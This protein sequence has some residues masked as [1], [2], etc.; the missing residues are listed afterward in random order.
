MVT[1]ELVRTRDHLVQSLPHKGPALMVD[2]VVEHAAASVKAQLT[3]TPD[4]IYV[5]H[6]CFETAGLIEHMAQTVALHKVI[7]AEEKGE[8]A[9]K[10]YL[11]AIKSLRVDQVIPVGSIIVTE[12]FILLDLHTAVKAKCISRIDQRVVGT[13]EM[14]FKILPKAVASKPRMISTINGNHLSID[15]RRTIRSQESH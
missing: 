4:N 3:V 7:E 5:R 9:Q 1:K 8:T 14:S 2:Q 6:G 11:T 13:A 12:I 15:I 10:G